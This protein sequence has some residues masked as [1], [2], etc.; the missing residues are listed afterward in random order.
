MESRLR[1]ARGP[2][3]T[4]TETSVTSM[5]LPTVCPKKS[6]FLSENFCFSFSVHNGF[7]EHLPL[8]ETDPNRNC[9][10][11]RVGPAPLHLL[12]LP[13]QRRSIRLTHSPTCKQTITLVTLS[14]TTLGVSKKFPGSA[15]IF[16]EPLNLK[17]PKTGKAPFKTKF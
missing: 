17:K 4:N 8:G 3:N 5:A 2:A 16:L 13:H 10:R 1:H 15:K 12:L 6:S 9:V 14:R 11:V 7:R